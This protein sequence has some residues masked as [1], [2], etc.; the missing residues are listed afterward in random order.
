MMI[1]RGNNVFPSTIEGIVREFEEIAEFRLE[2]DETKSM[3]ELRI[4]VEVCE[5]LP[6]PAT[7][8]TQA[9]RD[10][11]HFSPVVVVVEPGSLPRFELKA[12][13]VDRV[14]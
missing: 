7:L 5:G 6:G 3:T 14:K 9:I 11:L 1:I 13:R 4:L 12:N 8:L 2:V 10:R